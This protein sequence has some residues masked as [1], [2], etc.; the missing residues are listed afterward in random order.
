[1]SPDFRYV[2]YLAWNIGTKSSIDILTCMLNS[3]K[4]ALFLRDSFY[5]IQYFIQWKGNLMNK[6][7]DLSNV[8][9]SSC[10][11]GLSFNVPSL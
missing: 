2:N 11:D 6:W 7:V 3:N 5:P 8:A 9:W 4:F 1:M 10:G